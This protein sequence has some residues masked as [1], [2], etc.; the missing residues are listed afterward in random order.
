MLSSEIPSQ[1]APP[2]LDGRTLL[3]W[4]QIHPRYQ[5]KSRV[6]VWRDIRAKKFPAPISL[7]PRSVAWFEDEILAWLASR[8][9]CGGASAT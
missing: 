1:P 7:G 9:R 5:P 3:R 6:Q 2:S 8:P 4:N